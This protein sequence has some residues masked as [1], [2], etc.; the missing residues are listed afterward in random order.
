M[1][2][3]GDQIEQTLNEKGLNAPRVTPLDIEQEIASEHY[4]NLGHAAATVGH[5]PVTHERP[6][7][8][9]LRTLGCHTLCVL[10]LKNG[11]TVLGKSACA[12][13]ENYDKDL[14]E[15]IARKDAVSQ[16][17]PLLG[18]RLRDKITAD[19]LK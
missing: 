7:L 4:I 15:Q 1:S 8:D 6:A 11:F 2:I 3:T 19:S 14:G 10:V 17:W 12:S 16:L 18:F 5:K 13:P 9:E